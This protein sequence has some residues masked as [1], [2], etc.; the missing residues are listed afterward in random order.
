MPQNITDVN[1]WSTP[2]TCEADG[3][4]INGTNRLTHVQK[5]ANRT[6]FLRKRVFGAEDDDVIWI[7]L[8]PIAMDP[9]G[10]VKFAFGVSGAGGALNQIASTGAHLCFIEITPSAMKNCVIR[11][12]HLT[13]R[14][15]TGAPRGNPPATTMPRM[16]LLSKDPGSA[17]A[18]T[19]VATVTDT[20]ATGAAYET[21]HT[22]SITGLSTTVTNDGGLRYYIELQGETGGNALAG[23]EFHNLYAVVDPA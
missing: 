3:D 14:G 8:N 9:S 15:A 21:I 19:Q 22:I 23:L 13:L 10:G 2:L 18:P 11:E 17:A 20:T 6:E 4:A 5:E 7:S 12:L 16:R 1:T